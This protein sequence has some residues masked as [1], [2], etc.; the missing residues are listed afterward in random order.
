MIIC[1]R[2]FIASNKQF[3]GE[4]KEHLNNYQHEKNS[5]KILKELYNSQP[6]GGS[7]MIW[8]HI[9]GALSLPVFEDS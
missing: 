7:N 3:D 4:K 1:Y 5:P 8:I 6:P 9:L 2:L